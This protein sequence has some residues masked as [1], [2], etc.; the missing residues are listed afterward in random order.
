MSSTEITLRRNSK[1]NERKRLNR[2]SKLFYVSCDYIK[3]NSNEDGAKQHA[4]IVLNVNAADQ[5]SSIEQKRKNRKSKL[6]Y[7]SYDEINVGEVVY[8]IL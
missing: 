1:Q 4:G 6:F 2:R 8:N 5:K 3:V 7:V